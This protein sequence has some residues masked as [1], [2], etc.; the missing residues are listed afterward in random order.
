M[1]LS[2]QKLELTELAADTQKIIDYNDFSDISTT[3]DPDK[4]GKSPPSI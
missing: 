1:L 2:Y 4:Y 3:I